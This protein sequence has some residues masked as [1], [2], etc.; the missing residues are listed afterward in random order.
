MVRA[1]VLT[2]LY[3]GGSLGVLTFMLEMQRLQLGVLFTVL[4]SETS[5]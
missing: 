1:G 4:S 5:H 3:N 2:F